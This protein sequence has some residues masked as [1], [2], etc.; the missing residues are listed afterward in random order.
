MPQTAPTDGISYDGRERNNAEGPDIPLKKNP[1]VHTGG[2]RML[3]GRFEYPCR[4]ESAGITFCIEQEGELFKYRRQCGSS[5]AEKIISSSAGSLF[6]HPVEPVNLP[7]EVTR[8][9][10][11][12][13]PPVMM[14]PESEKT[15]F[16][17][18]PVEIGVILKQ[19]DECQLLDVFSRAAPKYSLY[20]T[21]ESGVITR[22]YHSDVFDQPPDTDP[23]ETGILRLIIHNTSKGWVEVARAVFE[24]YNMPIYFGEFVAMSA[25]MEIF[26][27]EIAE[28]KVLERPLIPEMNL[29]IPVICARKILRIDTERKRFLME[30][31]V[32]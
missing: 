10:E 5:D 8:F 26:S 29:A 6:V 31:G 32:R 4:Y 19:N 27:K 28:T 22:Y 1:F 9:L 21:P 2:N 12:E 16:L 25:L 30:H 15:L 24:S 13:F 18:F 7:K 23:A 14:A 3:Y 20:G 11:I 17:K